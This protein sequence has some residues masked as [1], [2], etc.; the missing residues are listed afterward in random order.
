MCNVSRA[1]VTD[2][3][4]RFTYVSVVLVTAPRDVLAARL[5]GRARASDGALALR[6]ARNDG[7]AGFAADYRIE[8]VGTAAAAIHALLDIIAA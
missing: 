8:N 7:F 1:V 4:A 3:R 5:A 2:A 6:L